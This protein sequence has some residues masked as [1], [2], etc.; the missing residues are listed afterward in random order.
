MASAVKGNVSSLP[1]AV[2]ATATFEAA[3]TLPA[4]SVALTTYEYVD[5][6]VSDAS[7]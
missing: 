6:G 7:R 1:G 4:A 5:P 2:V 3:E